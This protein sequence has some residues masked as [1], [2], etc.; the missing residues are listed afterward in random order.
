MQTNR[1]THFGRKTYYT[2][3]LKD[4][5]TI[6]KRFFLVPTLLIIVRSCKC[7]SIVFTV[8]VEY[9]AETINPIK[10][11]ENHRDSEDCVVST[12]R[13]KWYSVARRGNLINAREI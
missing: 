1:L 12:T 11:H 7:D 5:S 3:H 4:K 10:N 9:F 6:Q 2:T 13:S 8:D